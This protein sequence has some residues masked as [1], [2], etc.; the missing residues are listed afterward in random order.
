MQYYAFPAPKPDLFRNL[1]MEDT[2]GSFVRPF[3]EFR[4]AATKFES[5]M[6]LDQVKKKILTQW[7]KEV[8]KPRASCFKAD[9][10]MAKI[11][12]SECLHA[13]IV[14]D[15]TAKMLLTLKKSYELFEGDR[16]EAKCY[17]NR[18]FAYLNMLLC[19]GAEGT[20]V[21][22]LTDGRDSWLTSEHEEMRKAARLIG[23]DHTT[24]RR[25]LETK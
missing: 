6:T 21:E 16:A 12:M 19:A 24:H 17:T 7:L 3:A 10:E 18:L 8:E 23:K 9:S 4:C 15:D 22:I 14:L 2:L 20:F 5:G 11:A 25:L 1:K 13:Y